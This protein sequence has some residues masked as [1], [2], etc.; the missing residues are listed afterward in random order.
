MPKGRIETGEPESGSAVGFYGD[1]GINACENCRPAG[2]S[3]EVCLEWERGRSA[4]VF[5]M[6]VFLYAPGGGWL[7]PEGGARKN[8]APFKFWSWRAPWQRPPW[9]P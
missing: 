5:N 7:S 4:T 9:F 8:A 6:R 3:R 2:L 1:R